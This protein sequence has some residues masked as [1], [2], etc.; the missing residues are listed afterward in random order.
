M[1]ATLLMLFAAQAPAAKPVEPAPYIGKFM[2]G[3]QPIYCRQAPCPPGHY[4]IMIPGQ[5]AVSVSRIVY[6]PETPLA[7][8][9]SAQGGGTWPDG[10]AN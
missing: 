1:I 2:V 4:K 10:L 6:D 8:R 9:L 5:P 7:L 3:Y